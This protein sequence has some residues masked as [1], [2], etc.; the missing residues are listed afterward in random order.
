M[1]AIEVEH[2]LGRARDFF[3]GARLLQDDMAHYKF[4]SALL[5]IHCAISYADA[6]RVGMGSKNLSSDNHLDAVAD[7]ESMLTLRRYEKVKGATRLK[8]I[9][10][11]KS[12][13]AYNLQATN[14]KEAKEILLQVERFA[15]WA[16]ETGKN[17]N[18]EG[19]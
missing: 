6:L 18:I 7:L 10:S 2:F 8:A 3:E 4:S 9:L 16:E 19:W 12:Q 15:A 13:I 17:L 1:S 11:K 5:G 14:E